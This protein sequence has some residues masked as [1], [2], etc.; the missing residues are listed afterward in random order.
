MLT[1]E[2]NSQGVTR[3]LDGSGRSTPPS[4]IRPPSAMS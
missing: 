3:M 1:G 4:V 2:F